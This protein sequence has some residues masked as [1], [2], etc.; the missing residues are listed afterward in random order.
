MLKSRYLYFACFIL[1][2][3]FGTWRSELWWDQVFSIIPNLLGFSLAALAIFLGAGSEKFR[4]TISG[5]E[6]EDGGA[7]SPFMAATATFTHF[8]IVQLLALTLAIVCAALY[9]IPLPFIPFAS[10]YLVEANQLA[11]VILW[12]F[13]YGC[14]IYSICVAFAA[15]TSLFR[16]AGWF[17]LSRTRER[18][19]AAASRAKGSAPAASGTSAPNGKPTP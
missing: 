4:E 10:P 19:D 15:A 8:V 6:P 17:D 12:G 1:G 9:R 18:R 14:F 13:G 3:T 2:L 11:R 16:V 7:P 5:E